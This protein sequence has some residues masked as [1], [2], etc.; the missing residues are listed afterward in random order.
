MPSIDPVKVKVT[1]SC[2]ALCDPMICLYSPWK[3]LGQNNGVHSLSLF[4]GIIP[5]Q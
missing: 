4:Q 2:P 5:T 3:T 1:Q